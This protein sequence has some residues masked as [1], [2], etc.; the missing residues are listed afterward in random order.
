MIDRK[1][2]LHPVNGFLPFMRDQG[3]VVEE[4]I[5]PVVVGGELLGES[6]DG[7]LGGQVSEHHLHRVASR[8]CLYLFHGLLASAPVTADE[9]ETRTHL[10]KTLGRL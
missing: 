1:L 8:G 5:E 2:H 3:R 9:D 6:P 7:S 10:G 4:H